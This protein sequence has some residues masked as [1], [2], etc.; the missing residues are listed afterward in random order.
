MAS[1]EDLVASRGRSR[2][3][4]WA[5]Y[6]LEL[7]VIGVIYFALAKIGLMLAS[8]NPSASPIWPPTGVAFAAMLLRGYRVW[9]AILVGAFFANLTT[10]G[11]IATSLAIGVGNTTEGL[12]GAYLINR[13]S[14][15]KATFE[16]P[17]GVARFAFVSFL[18]TAVCATIGVISLALGGLAD[19]ATLGSV[20]L[21]WWLGD[22]AGALLVTPVIVL[23]W[24]AAADIR[25]SNRRDL[26]EFGRHLLCRLRDRPDRLQPDLCAG[27]A[28]RAARVP[29]GA[30][31][32]VVGAAPRPARHGDLRTGAGR[33]CGLGHARRQRAVRPRH[34]QR[35]PSCCC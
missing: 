34:P 30:A 35:I 33:L 11:S 18:P 21:T 3:H 19:T 4:A 12:L 23:W 32:V 9:P 2:L 16:T 29:R 6:T 26:F 14:D 25:S 22:L 8:I 20:W 13:L 7:C 24:A 31:A 10:A 5:L 17:A 1:S 15:G 28:A 27:G